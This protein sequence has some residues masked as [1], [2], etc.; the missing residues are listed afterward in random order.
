M[1]EVVWRQC[2]HKCVVWK[3]PARNPGAI[4]FGIGIIAFCCSI[5][6]PHTDFESIKMIAMRRI[7]LVMLVLGT[8][9]SSLGSPVQFCQDDHVHG[10]DICISLSVYPNN[11]S[12]YNDF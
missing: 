6:H 2:S 9:Q 4:L 10:Y 7:H 8:L 5:S 1:G 11:S 12:A 3:L